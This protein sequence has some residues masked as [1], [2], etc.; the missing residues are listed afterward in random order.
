V[1]YDELI[2]TG[3]VMFDVD[4]VAP[5]LGISRG[6]AYA[7]V[8]DGSIP[9]ISIGRRRLI[10]RARLAELVGEPVNDEGRPESGPR[11]ILD[12]KDT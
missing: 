1:T 6:L 2:A 11:E 3:R 5:V 4:E 8:R 7:G 10:P 12:G 9:S